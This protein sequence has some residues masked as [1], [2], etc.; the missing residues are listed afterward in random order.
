MTRGVAVGVLLLST[1]ALQG[2]AEALI[3]GGVAAAVVLAADR[4][5]TEVMLDDQSIEWTA[6]SRDRK[7]VV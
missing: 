4:R 7:S 1:A 2:C 5:Q 3:I 6:G